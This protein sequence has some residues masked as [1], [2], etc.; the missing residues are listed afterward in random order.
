M[1]RVGVE[2][3]GGKVELYLNVAKGVVREGVKVLL[4]RGVNDGGEEHG[5]ASFVL[6]PP[7]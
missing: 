1:K 5:C 2:C 7:R 6:G 4:P 3:D